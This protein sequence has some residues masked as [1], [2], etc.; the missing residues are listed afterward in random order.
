[1]EPK[2]G[3][4]GAKMAPKW[5]RNGA[6]PHVSKRWMESNGAEMGP[7]WGRNGAEMEPSHR[8]RYGME[9]GARARNIN[10]NRI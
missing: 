7:E 5:S 10:I 4:N 3:Q 9:P 1:M 6:R 2:W 8:R